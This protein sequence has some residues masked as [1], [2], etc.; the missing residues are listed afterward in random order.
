[1]LD[2]TYYYMIENMPMNTTSEKPA[3]SE[4]EAAFKEALDKEAKAFE[5]LKSDAGKMLSE[6]TLRL[7]EA[8]IENMDNKSE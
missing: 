5:D 2:Y 7:T 6:A 1:M 3:S 8:S 4:S